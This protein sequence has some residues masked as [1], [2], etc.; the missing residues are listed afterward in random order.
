MEITLEVFSRLLL[1]TNIVPAED[2]IDSAELCYIHAPDHALRARIRFILA[3]KAEQSENKMT[4][5]DISFR[6]VDEEQ[7]K[8]L[9]KLWRAKLAPDR[10]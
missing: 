5:S 1:V 3:D 2:F 10:S 4:R 9:T 8:R 7:L 6:K